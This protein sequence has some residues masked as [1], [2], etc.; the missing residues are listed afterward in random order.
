ML[1]Y[2]KSEEELSEKAIK[3]IADAGVTVI[4]AGGMVSDI[5]MHYIEK[6]K[7]MMVRIM[8]KFEL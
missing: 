6:Y 2:T 7:I 1:N 3:A 8:S 5:V 4:I